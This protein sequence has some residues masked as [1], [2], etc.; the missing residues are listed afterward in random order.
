M[1]RTFRIADNISYMEDYAYESV[2]TVV[3]LLTQYFPMIR[4]VTSTP[5]MSCINGFYLIKFHLDSEIR[6]DNNLKEQVKDFV[7]S[8]MAIRDLITKIGFNII[9]GLH[10]D[11]NDSKDIIA[12]KIK[13]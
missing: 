11:S 10:I 12:I 1:M 2:Y 5:E 3:S 4:M 9:I 6:V 8:E 7:E 13:I